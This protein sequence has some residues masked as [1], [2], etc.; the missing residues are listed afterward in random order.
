MSNAKFLY[1]K[2]S[3]I[4][5]LILGFI[6]LIL[7]PAASFAPSSQ[8]WWLPVLLAVMA[9]I[10]I[11]ELIVRKNQ[12][13]WPWYLISFAQGFNVISRLLMVMPRATEIV[14]GQQV[15]NTIYV[16]FSVIS[17]IASWLLLSYV[18]KPEVRMNL[19]RN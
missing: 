4:L 9:L 17:I 16:V 7:L 8:E 15:F 11:F 18:E 19:L 2:S 10:G 14:D 6:P 5:I 12:A 3:I 1:K 13:G